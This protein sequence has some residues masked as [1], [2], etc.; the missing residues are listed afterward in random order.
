MSEESLRLL[1]HLNASLNLLSTILLIVGFILIK[2][3]R[4]TAHRNVMLACFAVSTM[5]LIS[6]LVYHKFAGHIK[7]P[8]YP[9]TGVKYAYLTVL[10]THIVLAVFVPFL[11]IATIYCGLK[12]FRAAHRKL[13]KWTF[14]IWLYVSVTGVVVYLMLY[15]LF[16]PR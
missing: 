4:E 3:R 14:P 15:Q 16:P 12:D 7:F 6:Y 5:F 10:F 8:D 11:A 1:P 13:A 2:R 9:P